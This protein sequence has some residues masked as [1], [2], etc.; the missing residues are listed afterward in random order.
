MNMIKRFF[1]S[2]IAFSLLVYADANATTLKM[3]CRAKGQELFLCKAA[4]DEWC[5][6]TGHKVEIVT[7]PHASNEC[8]AL[9]QQWFSAES[10][11]VDIL[12]MDI[13][14]IDVFS[15]YLAPLENYYMGSDVLELDDYFDE[16]RKSMYN[17]GHIVALPWYTDCGVMYYRK[18]LLEKYNRSV[19]KTLEELYE[20]AYFIQEQERLD[21]S[22]KN[23]FFGFV[24][25]AKAYEVLTCNFAE[26]VDAFG[27]KI[28]SNGEI[29]LNSAPV[30][31][32]LKF[33]VSC[34][35]KITSKSVL[36]YS[37]ED[38]RGLFQS[39]N[40][41]FM[42]NWPYAWSLMNEGNSLVSGKVGVMQIPLSLKIY[43]QNVG[44]NN[45]QALELRKQAT[46][47]L[48]GWFLTVSKFSKNAALA[49][50][51]TKFLTNKTQQRLRAKYSYAP[52]FKSLY[53]D[54]EILRQ[55]PFFRELYYS[56]KN[57]VARPSSVF[58]RNYTRASN[59]IFNTVNTI[60]MEST[61]VNELSDEDL[62]KLL[63]RLSTSLN[64]LLKKKVKPMPPVTS[65][66]EKMVEK[67]Q[68]KEKDP[69]AGTTFMSRMAHF[70]GFGEVQE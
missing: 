1:S 11:D 38:A 61:S 41:V 19:P 15:E 25:Q 68:E 46:G 60:L 52:T 14:W 22:K 34:L 4:I 54:P 36:S 13:A 31:D 3:T 16:I 10:F 12:Q 70:F 24:F 17:D 56:L 51:L 33:M 67:Q 48:G 28:A 7:L 69:R 58:K 42:R 63:N 66:E 59:E 23:R 50:D 37:E 6:K 26:F 39:G 8:F 53:K 64:K 32:S 2:I 20:T 21:P 35:K 27:G 40:A 44:Q 5:Q 62:H 47:I 57:A 65:F 55:N 9:Y 49:A 18:D 43:Q 30:F 29:F 45:E